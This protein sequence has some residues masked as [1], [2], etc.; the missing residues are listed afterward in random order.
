[1]F[2]VLGGTVEV[3]RTQQCLLANTVP[4]PSTS[5]GESSVANSCTMR[6]ADVQLMG[7]WWPQTSPGRHVRQPSEVCSQ[8]G[9]SRAEHLMKLHRRATWCHLPQGITQCYLSP[10]SS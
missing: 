5:S 9:W 7:Q 4:Q 8:I 2:K 3:C 1:M 6:L 10:D